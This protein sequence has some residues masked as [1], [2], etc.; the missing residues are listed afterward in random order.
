MFMDHINSPEKLIAIGSQ[1]FE[2]STFFDL[3]KSKN[4]D[5]DFL[6]STYSAPDLE[7]DSQNQK[8]SPSHLKI[9]NLNRF[10]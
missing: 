8:K 6:E 5:R 9:K 3:E 2:K 4:F 7:I 10:L 1:R